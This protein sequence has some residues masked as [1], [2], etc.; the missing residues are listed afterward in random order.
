MI[1]VETEIRLI[2]LYEY[3]LDLKVTEVAR[4]INAAFGED[5][6]RMMKLLISYSCIQR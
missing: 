3:K 4:L 5:V 2:L 6:R 1:T